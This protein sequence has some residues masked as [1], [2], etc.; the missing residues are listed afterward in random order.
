MHSD[1]D[2]KSH[3]CVSYKTIVLWDFIHVVSKCIYSGLE[4]K[5]ETWFHLAI[6]DMDGNMFEHQNNEKIY[7]TNKMN[8]LI[9]FYK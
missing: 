6:A 5:E 1:D 9:T 8:Y 7:E 3:R 2:G 4:G